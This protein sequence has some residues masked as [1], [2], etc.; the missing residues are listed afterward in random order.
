MNYN[1]SSEQ[2]HNPLLKELLTVLTH[3][4]ESEGSSFYI[5][6]ATARDIVFTGIYNRP[7]SRMTYDLDI[8]IAIPDWERFS[9]IIE[10]LTTINGFI[11]HPNQHHRF[12]YRDRGVLDIVP[13]GE[14]AG[15]NKTL[16][17]PPDETIAM[18]VHGFSEA[19]NHAIEIT[20]D[21]TLTVKV[22]T[23]PGMFLL[24][25]FAWSD[26][27]LQSN[28]DAD[29]IAFILAN[30]LELNQE[31][32]IELHYDIY[33]AE[34]FSEI[35]AGAILLARDVRSLL[36]NDTGLLETLQKMLQAEE[37]KSIDSHLVAQIADTHPS[38]RSIEIVKAIRSMKLEL[39]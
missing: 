27:H 4:F 18:S 3:F 15:A 34:P 28:K 11:K 9:A 35:V 25:M 20:I 5:V 7:I 12:T 29:D 8:A 17:W 23:L 14:I 6:G 26:R 22:A 37:E 24:K 39:Q 31:R 38:L 19:F 30:Y 32:A 1:I 16:F 10:K 21:N 2:L 13:F 36:G 33:E